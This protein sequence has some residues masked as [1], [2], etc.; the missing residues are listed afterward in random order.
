MFSSKGSGGLL[1]RNWVADRLHDAAKRISSTIV[2]DDQGSIDSGTMVDA[3][4][5]S[6]DSW[7]IG[8]YAPAFQRCG[9]KV[10]DLRLG[11]LRHLGQG[12]TAGDTF[13][14]V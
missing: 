1:C 6:W 7:D 9:H 14:D 10:C 4:W 2:A 11:H 3:R 8:T 5:N 12:S 13:Y